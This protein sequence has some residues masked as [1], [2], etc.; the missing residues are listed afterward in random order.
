MKWP[1]K[2]PVKQNS[3]HAVVTV[4]SPMYAYRHSLC[5]S[6]LPIFSFPLKNAIVRQSFHSAMNAM[7]HNEQEETIL[8]IA[9]QE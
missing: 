7:E 1:V 5:T 9:A 2:R 8:H 6:R 3:A 4:A